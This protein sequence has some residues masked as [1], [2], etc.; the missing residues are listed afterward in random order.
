MLTFRSWR[1]PG[2]FLRRRPGSDL[3]EKVKLSDS[4]FSFS[5]S[6]EAKW[7]QIR[8]IHIAIDDTS[9][10]RDSTNPRG[11]LLRSASQISR[12]DELYG[13]TI[14][15]IELRQGRAP[16]DLLPQCKIFTEHKW[17]G[18]TRC[19]EMRTGACGDAVIIS[20]PETAGLPKG[21]DAI[22]LG[23]DFD[24]QPCCII[25]KVSD[26]HVLDLPA[27]T[28]GVSDPVK[29]LRGIDLSQRIELY[30]DTSQQMAP[31][32]FLGFW[33]LK[34]DIHQT[35]LSV[36]LGPPNYI[37]TEGQDFCFERTQ[38]GV[39][40]TRE[41][42]DGRMGWSFA[43]SFSPCPGNFCHSHQIIRDEFLISPP[44][45]IVSPPG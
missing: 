4:D 17:N 7:R 41:L 11:L 28:I 29:E 3:F 37:T 1:Q 27:G 10:T 32:T 5:H 22:K 35:G 40:I 39:R 14:R 34:G 2:L 43:M 6:F 20:L 26:G 8:D 42:S 36:I 19:L 33:Y 15:S 44:E 18:N 12:K 21:I 25:G 24:F 16:V 45:I 31:L 23:F 38:I 13:F 30:H 9:T